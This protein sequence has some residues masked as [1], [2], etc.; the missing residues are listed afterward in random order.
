MHGGDTTY[1]YICCACRCS[2]KRKQYVSHST[3]RC[4]HCGKDMWSMGVDFKVPR[5]RNDKAWAALK[6]RVML[7]KR[8]ANR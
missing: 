1:K 7:E 3:A 5:K 4:Q 8:K 6:R 2:A